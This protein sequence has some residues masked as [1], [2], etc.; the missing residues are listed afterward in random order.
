MTE[1]DLHAP[2]GMGPPKDYADHEPAP[3]EPE[4]VKRPKLVPDAASPG[5]PEEEAGPARALTMHLLRM[6]ETR[7]DAAGIALNNEIQSFSLRLQLKLL[8]AAAAFI[9]IWG[10]IVLLAIVLPDPYRAPV[11]GLVVAGFVGLGLWAYLKSKKA[12]GADDVGS[13]RWFLDGLRLD[14]EV[15]S[16]ALS[17]RNN[18][19][20]DKPTTAPNDLAA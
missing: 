11:L 5:E 4:I 15:L 8:A 20:A 10:A 9:S 7:F 1:P 3:S 12:I 13:M 19:P 17:P 18:P 16:R 6:I 2:N 14:F